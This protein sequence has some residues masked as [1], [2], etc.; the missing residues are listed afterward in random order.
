M[1]IS[2]LAAGTAVQRVLIGRYRVEGDIPDR[3]IVEL[4]RL[5]PGDES[6]VQG[7]NP[8]YGGARRTGRWTAHVW[9]PCR[10]W[11]KGR[12]GCAVAG[13]VSG[14]RTGCEGRQLGD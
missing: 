7:R 14:D 6:Q 2:A 9:T 10:Q 1:R 12:G 4:C 8:L 5:S 13:G 3:N 11:R